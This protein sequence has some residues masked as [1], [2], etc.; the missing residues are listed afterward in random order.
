MAR[1]RGRGLIHYVA[2]VLALQGGFSSAKRAHTETPLAHPLSRASSLPHPASFP[3][4]EQ[5]AI[6]LGQQRRQRRRCFSRKE[7]ESRF[8][9]VGNISRVTVREAGMDGE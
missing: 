2:T 3:S 9:F 5:T 6:L 8:T 1:Q 7:R 4:F